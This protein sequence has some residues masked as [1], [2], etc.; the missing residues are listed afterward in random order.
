[1]PARIAGNSESNAKFCS[2]ETAHF[3]PKMHV[4]E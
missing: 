1:M 2:D 3:S 4:H